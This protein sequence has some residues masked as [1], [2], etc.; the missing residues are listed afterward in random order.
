MYAIYQI[1]QWRNTANVHR[2]FTGFLLVFPAISMGKCCKNQKET[3]YSSKIKSVYFV[4]KPFNV[5]RLQ[6]NPII[7]K[8]FSL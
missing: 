6:E 2:E 3:L 1:L 8:R 7:T 5:Y 4:G